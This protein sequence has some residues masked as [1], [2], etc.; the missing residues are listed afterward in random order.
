MR[1]NIAADSIHTIHHIS[2]TNRRLT[3]EIKKIST[4]RNYCIVAGIVYW[5]KHNKNFKLLPNFKPWWIF[6]RV[7]YICNIKTME[8]R[9][10]TKSG[11][12]AIIKPASPG[13][14]QT[15]NHTIVGSCVKREVENNLLGIYFL[16]WSSY[17]VKFGK[18]LTEKMPF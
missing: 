16:L 8:N 4:Q 10:K 11:G 15:V 3:R 14:W 12:V 6:Y 17:L 18:N 13:H 9:G 7:L 2:A 5:K 1:E